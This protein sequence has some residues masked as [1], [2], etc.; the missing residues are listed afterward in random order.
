MSEVRKSG[1]QGEQSFRPLR[2]L[3]GWVEEGEIGVRNDLHG[4]PVAYA[5]PCG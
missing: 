4:R 3:S 5:P 1:V 2:V